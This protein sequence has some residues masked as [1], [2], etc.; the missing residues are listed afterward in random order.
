MCETVTKFDATWAE[1]AD[2][3]L[4]FLPIPDGKPNYHESLKK[5]LDTQFFGPNAQ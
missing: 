5:Y 1:K 3:M 4:A 2:Q